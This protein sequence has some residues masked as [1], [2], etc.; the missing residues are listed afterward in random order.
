MLEG[1][2]KQNPFQIP[3]GY[4]ENLPTRVSI[5]CTSESRKRGFFYAIKPQFVYAAS[6]GA[7][8]VVLTFGLVKF[9]PNNNSSLTNDFRRKFINVPNPYSSV[10]TKHLNALFDKVSANNIGSYKFSDNIDTEGVINYLEGE[11]INME[12]ILYA[13]L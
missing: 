2:F 3:E 11:N 13:G 10:S 1:N 6:F 4:F 8:L 9:N 7:V 5:I 12:D